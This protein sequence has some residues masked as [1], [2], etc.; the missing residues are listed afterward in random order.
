VLVKP[1]LD[2]PLVQPGLFGLV[3]S[4]NCPD[5]VVGANEWTSWVC[6]RVG[7]GPYTGRFDS[8]PAYAHVQHH[9]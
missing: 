8:V 9:L 2:T 6:V 5:D 7:V 4:F 3:V 1:R